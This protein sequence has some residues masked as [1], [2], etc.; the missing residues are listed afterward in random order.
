VSLVWALELEEASVDTL[1]DVSQ[2]L[3]HELVARLAVQRSTVDQLAKSSPGVPAGA[4]NAESGPS[5]TLLSLCGFTRAA[6]AGVD[7]LEKV[8][9]TAS[10]E[11][12]LT[13]ARSAAAGALAQAKAL[14]EETERTQNQRGLCDSLVQRE[15]AADDAAVQKRMLSARL[16]GQLLAEQET[17]AKMPAKV[18]L[19]GAAEV[20]RPA[21]DRALARE[22]DA[23]VRGELR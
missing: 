19:A 23:Q 9:V 17:F 7:A 3:S 20:V 11:A 21:L 5:W 4:K 18:G 15:R 12:E 8:A 16:L 14:Q 2:V 10:N 22:P 6:Q 13:K 1:L